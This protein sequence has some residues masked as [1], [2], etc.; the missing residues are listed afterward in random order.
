[1]KDLFVSDLPC[2][3]KNPVQGIIPYYN[4]LYL[5]EAQN[6]PLS[7]THGGSF[8]IHNAMHI[9]LPQKLVILPHWTEDARKFFPKQNTDFVAWLEFLWA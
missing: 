2:N 7:S 8:S 5:T 1:M 3:K 4:V 6:T 9:A